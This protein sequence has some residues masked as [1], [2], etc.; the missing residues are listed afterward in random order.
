[1]N[2]SIR[3]SDSPRLRSKLALRRD[4]IVQLTPGQGQHTAV[5]CTVQGTNEHCMTNKEAVCTES[6][7]DPHSHRCKPHTDGCPPHR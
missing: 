6:P 5:P 2:D 4:T 3:P 1:M 7:T